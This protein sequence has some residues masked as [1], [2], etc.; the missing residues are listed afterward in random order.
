[1]LATNRLPGNDAED[2]M[3]KTIIAGLTALALAGSSPSF[4]Q[5]PANQG[6]KQEHYHPS[7]ADIKAFTDAR[8]AGLKAGLALTP[9][10]EKSWPPVEQAIRDMAQARQARVQQWREQRRSEDTIGKLRARADAMTQRAVELKK[11]ADAAEP[12]YRSLTEE[13]KHRL[14]FLM[15]GMMAHHGGGH[16]HGWRHDG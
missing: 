12:L 11:L 10:Q 7:P 3:N 14:R 8:I 16:R 5:E 15:R 13:Q 9:D 6:A 4:A 1:M 2:V